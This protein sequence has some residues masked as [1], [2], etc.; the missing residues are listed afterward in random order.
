MLTKANV[1]A[2]DR[3]LLKRFGGKVGRGL[4]LRLSRRQEHLSAR[5]FYLGRSSPYAARVVKPAPELGMM[6]GT[7]ICLR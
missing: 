1:H 2:L 5:N 6:P 3:L 7:N 4:A